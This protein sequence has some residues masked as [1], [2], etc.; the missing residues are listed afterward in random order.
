MTLNPTSLR[1]TVF[2]PTS[3]ALAMFMTGCSDNTATDNNASSSANIDPSVLADTQE[4]VINNGTEPESLDPHKVS[5]VPESN[6]GRQLFEGLT[7]TDADGKTIP[8]MAT[9]WES[10]DN[11]VWT[12]KLRDAKWSNGDPVTAQDFVYSMRRLVDPNTA[13]P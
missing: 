10:I 2:L 12:F 7:N 4:M 8:G 13:S 6:I 3:L 11:K 5:G 1:T 9:E